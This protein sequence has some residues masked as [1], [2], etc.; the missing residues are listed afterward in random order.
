MCQQIENY[1]SKT[2]I[3][4]TNCRDNFKITIKKII[5]IN[6]MNGLGKNSMRQ[7]IYQLN[8]CKHMCLRK[9]RWKSTVRGTNAQKQSWIWLNKNKFYCQ[10]TMINPRSFWKILDQHYPD[11]VLDLD[12]TKTTWCTRNNETYAK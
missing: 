9:S 6:K 8:I 10:K 11:L 1:S 2:L 3:N 4:L 12:S 5:Q 7:W